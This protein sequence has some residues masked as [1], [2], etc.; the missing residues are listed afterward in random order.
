[1]NGDGLITRGEWGAAAHPEQ[2]LAQSAVDRVAHIESQVHNRLSDQQRQFDHAQR[3][4]EA[5]H[6]A[7]HHAQ[8]AVHEQEASRQ[9][10]AAFG[11]PHGHEAFGGSDPGQLKVAVVQMANTISAL[12][13]CCCGV[14]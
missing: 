10:L 14:L 13:V 5:T 9:F 8:A 7:A 12:Q 3:L 4:V 2:F 6:A 1:M 11:A